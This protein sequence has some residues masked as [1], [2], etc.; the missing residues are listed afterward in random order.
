MH[1]LETVTVVAEIK[2]T[3]TPELL[4]CPRF[5]KKNNNLESPL[6]AAGYFPAQPGQIP[7]ASSTGKA[8]RVIEVTA[9]SPKPVSS[10]TT[11]YRGPARLTS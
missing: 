5:V 9:S 3:V 6:A 10:K 4:Q 11:S 1:R 8:S 2:L 7:Q